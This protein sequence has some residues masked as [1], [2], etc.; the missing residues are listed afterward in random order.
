MDD[1]K[2]FLQKL[3]KENKAGILSLLV[4][5]TI[6]K[7]K[8]PMYGYKI[9]QTIEELADYQIKFQEGSLYAVLR[10]LQKQGMLESYIEESPLGPP[11]KYYRITKSGGKAVRAGL[12]DW[13]AIVDASRTV[14]DKLGVKN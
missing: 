10:S 3:E 11:R 7:A 2:A 8:E 1:I 6:K 4:L 12:K 14:F 9:I 13:S 5:S